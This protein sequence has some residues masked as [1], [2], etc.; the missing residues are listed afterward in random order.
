MSIRQS[1]GRLVEETPFVDTHEHLMEESFRVSSKEGSKP[2]RALSDFSALFAHYADS[3]L[4]VA[5]LSLDGHRRLFHPDTPLDE[6]WRLLAPAYERARHTGYLQNV[7]ESLRMLYGVDDI[8]ADN[9]EAVSE[10][11]ADRIRPGYYRSVL[12]DVARVE[13]CQVN[14]LEAPVF[15]LTEQPDLLAQ[16][17]SFV[18][19]STGLDV[20]GVS[21]LLGVEVSSLRDWH[22]VIDRC[23]EL[24][25][26]RAVAAKNQSAY[27]RRLD[28]AQ[29]STD[30]AA[31]LF[32]RYLQEPDALPQEELKAIQDHLFHYCVDKATEYSLPVK[33]HTGYYAGTNQMPLDRVG[34]NMEDMCHLLRAHPDARFVIMHIAYP[35]ADEAIAVAKH[36]PNAYV[37]LCWAWIIN[38][39]A[40][41]RFLKEFLMAAPACK[42]LTFGG[43]YLY[44]EMVPGH[45][46]IARKGLTQALT[47]LVEE[48]WV[49]DEDVPALVE[50]LMRGNAHELFDLEGTLS[51]AGAAVGPVEVGVGR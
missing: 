32:E 7:R 37:D 16:D 12:K 28:Y 4:H 3:D 51:S 30:E 25:G 19:L 33:L 47:E 22:N 38:P 10:R 31:P 17:I 36:Y 24:Y 46:R 43:D 26:P 20:P 40:S 15:R 5:G 49:E 23:F 42:L 29:V 34:R 8:R 6:K 9:Y 11:V 39:L 35:Y 18:S 48:G 44:V 1:I 45:A 14:A 41:V 2:D 13:Y 21:A 50:R 27:S